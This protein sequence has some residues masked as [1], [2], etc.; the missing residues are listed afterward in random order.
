LNSA[1]LPLK[2]W[3]CDRLGIHWAAIGIHQ[4]IFG[5]LNGATIWRD[6][7][8]PPTNEVRGGVERCYDTTD[9]AFPGTN[10]GTGGVTNNGSRAGA[11]GATDDGTGLVRAGC[12][13]GTGATGTE[14]GERCHH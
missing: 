13:A 7:G 10:N 1:L 2:W 11:N 9:D 3:C 14:Q 12:V 5:N 8:V 4:N 6:L